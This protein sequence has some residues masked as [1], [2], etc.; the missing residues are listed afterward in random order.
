MIFACVDAR[1]GTDPHAFT[2]DDRRIQQRRE[3]RLLM[4]DADEQAMMA[5]REHFP[6]DVTGVNAFWSQKRAEQAVDWMDRR[7][8]KTLTEAQC[9][10]GTR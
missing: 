2:A 5:W 8:Q 10:L 1:E 3:H 9:D 6:Q 7:K 4:V